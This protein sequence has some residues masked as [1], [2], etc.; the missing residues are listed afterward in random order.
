MHKTPTFKAKDWNHLM[1]LLFHDSYMPKL[2]RYRSN[3]AYRGLEDSSYQL[4][5]TLKRLGQVHLEKHLLRNFIKYSTI[6]DDQRSIWKWLTIGQHHGLPTRLLDW[7]YS[8][9]VALH[10]ATANFENFNTDALIWAI[11]YKQTLD[12]LP[13]GKLLDTYLAEGSHIFTIE[14]L[15]NSGVKGLKGLE[16]LEKQRN[17]PFCMFFEP[18]S[19]NGRIV[20]QYAL[21]SMISDPDLT[22][23]DWVKNKEIDQFKILIPKELKWEIRDKLDQAN[24]N[25]RV[26]FPGLDGLASWL[27]RQYKDI[28]NL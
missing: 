1:E 26:L 6:E 21:F 11:N 3:Y 17:E 15:D 9:L 23:D 7:T 18:P 4:S 12:Q 24:I 28:T 14:M 5:T 2:K 22:I 20:N 10:F 16:D 8:P 27:K 19:I 13:P 25:E